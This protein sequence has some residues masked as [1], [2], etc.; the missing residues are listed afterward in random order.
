MDSMLA[1]KNNKRDGRKKDIASNSEI[2]FKEMLMSALDSCFKKRRIEHAQCLPYNLNE[3]LFTEGNKIWALTQSNRTLDPIQPQYAPDSFVSSEIEKIKELAAKHRM[4]TDIR[5]A[6]FTALVSS[7]VRCFPNLQ[8]LLTHP[9]DFSSAFE[10]ILRL[11]LKDVQE[12]EILKVTIHCALQEKAFNPFYAL[13]AKR[14]CSYKLSFKTTSKYILWDYFKKMDDSS[15]SEE[16][17]SQRVINLAKI[18]SFLYSGC[19]LS[20]GILSPLQFIA[21]SGKQQLFLKTLFH[22]LFTSFFK[23]PDEARSFVT[24][25]RHRATAEG[26][27]LFF[28]AWQASKYAIPS[29]ADISSDGLTKIYNSAHDALISI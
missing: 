14:F 4:N 24:K 26:L 2:D 12:R 16:L 22:T 25:S 21:L 6:I 23:S 15:D 10:N 20:L 17:N 27:A 28:K 5:K 8:T 13:V 7:K 3:I 18:Y 1:L 11:N 29:Y 19:N 9:K